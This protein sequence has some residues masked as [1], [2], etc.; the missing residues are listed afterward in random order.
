MVSDEK[1]KSLSTEISIQDN[2]EKLENE[3][4]GGKDGETC[5]SRNYLTRTVRRGQWFRHRST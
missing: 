4:Q 3:A 2:Q 1:F 5:S